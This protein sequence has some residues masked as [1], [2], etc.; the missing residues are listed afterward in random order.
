MR[1]QKPR[2]LQRIG[3]VLVDPQRQRHH[4]AQHQIAVQRAGHSPGGGLGVADPFC[5]LGFGR[6]R[7]AA[8]HIGVAADVFGGGMRDHI[9]AQLQR[10]LQIGRGEGVVHHADAAVAVGNLGDGGDVDHAQ[11]R[12]G[13]R[14]HPH[15]LGLGAPGCFDCGEVL[16]VDVVA[17]HADGAVGAGDE[18]IG[19]AIYDV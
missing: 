10:V 13:G 9:G 14:L 17:A 4:A 12:V 7:K 1:I 3:A 6:G 8:H 5:Q 18:A 16:E 2:H 15:Q 19:A 11:Q